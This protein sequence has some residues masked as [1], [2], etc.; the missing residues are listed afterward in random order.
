[1]APTIT[2]ESISLQQLILDQ[3]D[4][5]QSRLDAPEEERHR[6]PSCSQ[7]RYWHQVA[8]TAHHWLMQGRSVELA[9]SLSQVNA[10][11]RGLMA[12]SSHIPLQALWQPEMMTGEQW[13]GLTE[14]VEKLRDVSLNYQPSCTLSL[15]RDG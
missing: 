1:M 13:E 11:V 3:L 12:I 15:R 14:G 2:I 8:G 6:T 5:I 10:C 9:A 7:L 4:A